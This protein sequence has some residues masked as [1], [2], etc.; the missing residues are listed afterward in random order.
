[1]NHQQQKARTQSNTMTKEKS[2]QCQKALL[3]LEEITQL[4]I[5]EFQ[6]DYLPRMYDKYKTKLNKN[7]AEY[8]LI[9]IILKNL[10]LDFLRTRYDAKSVDT[11]AITI[12]PL[13]RQSRIKE[14]EQYRRKQQDKKD[15][16]AQKKRRSAARIEEGRI[17]RERREAQRIRESEKYNKERAIK[18][19]NARLEREKER[20]RA[21]AR[22]QT[23]AFPT[24]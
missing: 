20:E 24:L 19:E 23:K 15:A 5:D 10:N 18:T 2:S 22:P 14:L 3:R 1:M 4:S 9:S 12:A 7:S 17:E 11:F 13:I 6:S 21:S 16:E 8:Q